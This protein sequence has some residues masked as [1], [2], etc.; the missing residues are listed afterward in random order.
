MIY[1]FSECSGTN[2]PPLG[3]IIWLICRGPAT[4][5]AQPVAR[6]EVIVCANSHRQPLTC[7]MIFALKQR[8]EQ[9]L[10]EMAEDNQLAAEIAAL[11]ADIEALKLAR[12]ESADAASELHSAFAEQ[13]TGTQDGAPSPPAQEH[14]RDVEAALQDLAETIETDIGQRPMASIA[15]AFLIGFFIGRLSAR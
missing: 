3:R 14:V 7:G 9:G 10:W 11:R 13:N 12:D 5:L 15:A 1:G 2:L 6:G 8:N 4:Q